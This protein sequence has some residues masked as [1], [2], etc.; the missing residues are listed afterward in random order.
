[1]KKQYYGIN[2]TGVIALAVAGIVLYLA[3]MAGLIYA[4]VKIVRFAWG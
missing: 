1:M 3:A 2:S 4:A